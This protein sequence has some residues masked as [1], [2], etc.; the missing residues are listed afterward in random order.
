MTIVVELYDTSARLV[1]AS[2]I[3][4]AINDADG[5][6]SLTPTMLNALIANA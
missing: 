2:G 1:G 3:V 4:A 6:K 5:D